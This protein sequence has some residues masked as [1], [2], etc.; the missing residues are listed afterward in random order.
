M[1]DLRK[2]G[3]RNLANVAKIADHEPPSASADS[4]RKNVSALISRGPPLG[5]GVGEGIILIQALFR[6]LGLF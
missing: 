6:V 1:P 5:R 3:L 2:F 4:L